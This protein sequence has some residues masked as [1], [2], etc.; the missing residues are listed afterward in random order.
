MKIFFTLCIS[1]S[2]FQLNAQATEAWYI[3]RSPPEPW[4]WAPIINTN[5][6]EMDYFFA[7]T[8]VGEWNSGY[9]DS[10]DVSLAFGPTSNFV[11]LEGGDDHAIE[12]AEFIAANMSIIEDWVFAGGKLFIEAAP[13]EGGDIDLGFGGLV[14]EYEDSNYCMVGIVAEPTHPIFSSPFA[15]IAT[16]FNGNYFG[17]AY[18]SG[19]GLTALVTDEETN[20]IVIGELSWGA[21]KVIVAGTTVTS[22][23]WPQPDA[24]YMRYNIFHYLYVPDFVPIFT[25]FYRDADGD[26]FG[27][28]ERD[29]IS[30]ETMLPGYV[31]DNTDCDDTNPLIYPGAVEILNLIDD[32]CNG[33]FDDIVGVESNNMAMFSLMPNPFKDEFILECPEH[34]T[35]TIYDAIGNVVMTRSLSNAQNIIHTSSLFPGLYILVCSSQYGVE[36]MRIIKNG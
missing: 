15:P 10:V 19:P 16:S 26:T 2:L 25:T 36:T 5:I 23:H 17:H 32:D 30:C 20:E 1:L 6:T 11:F 12:M 3:R 35:I 31:L 9:Y 33:T 4:T 29:S 24:V 13:N 34:S 22:W 14:I 28:P 27:N 7:C 18:V 8:E 21:G